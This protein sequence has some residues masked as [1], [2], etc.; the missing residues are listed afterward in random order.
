MTQWLRLGSQLT[1]LDSQFMLPP[2]KPLIVRHAIETK[3]APARSYM[4]DFA[5]AALLIQSD[6][7]T[8]L[9][10]LMHFVDLQR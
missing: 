8:R 2:D 3:A 5:Q 10:I 4:K 7:R 1:Q 9:Y 6:Q